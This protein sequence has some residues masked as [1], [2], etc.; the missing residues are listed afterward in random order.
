MAHS[1]KR[2]ILLGPPGAGKGTQAKL[3][4]QRL[5]CPHLS[6]GDLL[7]RAVAERTDLGVVAK[8]FMDQGELVPN[9]LVVGMIEERVLGGDAAR[10]FILDGF[11]RNVVQAEALG[12]MLQTRGLAVEH[13]FGL[14]VPRAE[15]LR[16]LSGR[17]TCR[18]CN[19]M[20]HVAF[21]PP[22]SEGVC[23]R[24]GGE[25]FQRDDD[26]EET[27]S[28]RLDVYERETLPLCDYYRQRAL[29]R[30]ID[31]VGSAEEVLGRILAFMD[32]GQ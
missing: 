19:A 18:S 13:V 28:A 23:D 31:A 4:E 7:R 21:D 32:G 15:L 22:R 17:R 27:I 24:C 16:R 14:V 1:V 8:R 26:K 3:M 2:V 20:Y 6:S 12:R 25:L 10:G 5:G 9:D 30:E 11:P 29:L